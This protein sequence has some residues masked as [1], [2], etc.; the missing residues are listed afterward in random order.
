MILPNFLFSPQT[1][2]WNLRLLLL[3]TIVVFVILLVEFPFT[4]REEYAAY[5]DPSYANAVPFRR[6]WEIL[7]PTVAFILLHHVASVKDWST[8]GLAIA[9]LILIFAET[10]GMIAG[11]VAVIGNWAALFPNFVKFVF[12]PVGISLALSII[13]RT[14][15]I[16]RSRGRFFRQRFAFL[17]ECTHANPAYTPSAILLNRSVARPLVR[18]EAKTII[19]VRAVILT[20]IALGLPAF[21]IYAMIVSPVRASVYTR[22]VAT[23]AAGDLVSPQGGVTVLMGFFGLNGSIPTL[24]DFVVNDFTVFGNG[25]EA[26]CSV[27]FTN[28]GVERLVECLVPWMSLQSSSISIN[29]TI[30]SGYIVNIMPLSEKPSTTPLGGFPS[31][32]TQAESDFDSAHLQISGD[33]VPL[34]PGSHLFGR[35]T[36]TQRETVSRRVLGI[37]SSR[38]PAFAADIT[39]LQPYPSDSTT[40]T[41]EATLMLFVPYPYA[42]K[43][44]QDSLDTTLLSGLSTFGGFWTT[45]E[46]IFVLLFGANVMYFAMGRRPMSALGLI[47]IFQRR[48]LVRRWHTDFPALRTEGGQPGSESAGVVAFIR[49][50]LIDVGQDDQTND[51][52]AQ[53]SRSNSGSHEELMG[54]PTKEPGSDHVE[55]INLQYLSR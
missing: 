24:T 34:V 47:H 22:F 8:P 53:H 18:G 7:F 11:F 30:P 13:F 25:R 28:P 4:S 39:G 20:C 2:V 27:T 19:I 12:I 9:D 37:P 29:L 42:I 43:L 21:G 36:W 54:V 23:F 35:L 3:S 5:G 26:N 51:T 46:G 15:T 52:E 48:T 55:K 31:G 45:I 6:P 10:G 40:G 33:S 32:Y 16:V 1:R 14:A 38:K 17:G 44:Q 49:E 50:R 41:N